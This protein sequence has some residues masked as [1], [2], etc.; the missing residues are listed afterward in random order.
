VHFFEN[1]FLALTFAKKNILA[2][3]DTKKN[4]LALARMEILLPV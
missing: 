4:I 3:S 2:L 1:K